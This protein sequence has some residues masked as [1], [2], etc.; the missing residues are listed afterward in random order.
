M[1]LPSLC[2]LS[3]IDEPTNSLDL[4]SVDALVSA[5]ESYRGRLIIVS[6]DGAFLARCQL[7][8]WLELD[9][10]GLHRIDPPVPQENS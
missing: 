5:L 7:D 1:C 3:L 9:T 8:T 4:S 2:P 6:H 10:S